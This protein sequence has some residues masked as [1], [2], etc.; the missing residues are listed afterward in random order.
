MIEFINRCIGCLSCLVLFPFIILKLPYQGYPLIVPN[1]TPPSKKGQQHITGLLMGKSIV[2]PAENQNTGSF[3]QQQ[4]MKMFTIR[5]VI[6]SP[7]DQQIIKILARNFWAFLFS[8][9]VQKKVASFN[10]FCTF[11]GLNNHIN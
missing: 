6:L 4:L 9:N 11:Q 5:S 1:A 3:S 7:V 8:Y 10:N 2:Y